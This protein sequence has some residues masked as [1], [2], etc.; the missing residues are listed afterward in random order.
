M[1]VH[2]KNAVC[3]KCAH[4]RV[5]ERAREHVCDLKYYVGGVRRARKV[6]TVSYKISSEREMDYGMAVPKDCPYL[7]EQTI[8][9]ET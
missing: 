7:L 5:G 9:Q 3:K 6:Y 2:A 1:R 4:Y 8:S